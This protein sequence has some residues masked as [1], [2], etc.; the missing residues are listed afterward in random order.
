MRLTDSKTLIS[1]AAG[2]LGRVFALHLLRA[3]G[4]V[5]AGDLDAAGLRA[6][7][8]EAEGLPGRL[9]VDTLDV[10]DEAGVAAFVD[11][12][13]DALQGINGLIN[14]AGIL[15]DGLLVRRDESGDVRRLP[16]ALWRRV[17]E[18]NL[19]GCFLMVREFAARAV[20]DGVR[21]GFVVNLSS[22]SRK[23]NHGQAGYAASKAGLDAATRSWALELADHGIRVGAVAPGVV[24]TPFLRGISDS[25]LDRLRGAVP[26]QRIGTPDEIWQAVC[27]IIECDYFTGRVLEVDG[28][29][30]ID[31]RA[32][33]DAEPVL[34]RRMPQA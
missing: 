34:G 13:A 5:A 32:Q 31:G 28:G 1:G 29:A 27:F 11:R 3:G 18:V 4:D 17:V 19:T 10:T 6:L 2:G 25:A 9:T 24:G 21:D 20:A 14:C 8:R 7:R 15:G 12:A 16:T 26:L 33:L 30:S 22:L 23:G